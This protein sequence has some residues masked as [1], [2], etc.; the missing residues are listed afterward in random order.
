M[1]PS[2]NPV[3]VEPNMKYQ[4]SFENYVLSYQRINDQHYY[5]KYKRALE[6]FSEYIQ[7]LHDG[8]IRINQ[9][10]TEI[11]TST[12]W[13]I[14]DDEVVG[15][16]RIRH[17]ADA[18]GGHIG[19][20]ISPEYRNKGYGQLILKA[21]LSKAIDIGIR[22]VIL[23]CSVDNVASRIIIEKCHGVFTGIVHDEEENEVLNQFIIRI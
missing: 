4:K 13:F 23:T 5:D 12:F 22:E 3:L 19:Y 9:K 8:S 17:Q 14:D 16:A 7:Y 10:P 21:A 15:V 18:Y 2:I 6:N 1:T 11:F 20:D